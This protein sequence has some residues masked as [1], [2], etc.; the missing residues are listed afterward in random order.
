MK[1]LMSCTSDLVIKHAKAAGVGICII[2]C[3][4]MVST[5]TMAELIFRPING[6]SLEKELSYEETLE[7]LKDGLLLAGEQKSASTY[8]ELALLI[9]SGFVAILIEGQSE[10]LTVGVQGYSSRSVEEPS[11]HLNVRAARDSFVE[12]IRTNVSLI[13]RR[14]KTPQLVFKMKKLGNMSKTDVCICYMKNR[15]DPQLVREVEKRLDKIGLDS[16]LESGYLQPFLDVRG[17]ALFSEVGATERPDSFT[18]KLYG[19]RV[20]VLV[21]GSPFGLFL[22]QLFSENFTAMDDYTGRP[23]YS[24]VIRTMRYFAYFLSIMLAGFYVALANFNPELIPQTLLLN[25]S[26]SVQDTPYPLLLECI[27]IHIFFEMMREAG[28]RIPSNIGHA[29]SIVGGLVI[30]EIVVSAGLVGAPLVLIVAL[31][32]ICSFVVP[33]LYESIAVM[34]FCYIIA[35][36]MWGLFGLTVLTV[37]FVLKICSMNA[38]GVPATAPISPLT[39]RALRDVITR[40]GW[41]K[42]SETDVKIQDLNG[43]GING[44]QD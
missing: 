20:G 30:G 44:Q 18:A 7:Q 21:D 25:L 8:G 2:F 35:G 1:T 42:A 34:R 29:V 15:A 28:L 17:D 16:L 36:G 33:D 5:S 22:P 10:A 31:S 23:A 4:G 24:A 41:R 43:V 6:L 14:M 12:V 11:T 3:E 37:L 40:T 39:F 27:I 19:G 13:R 38:F 32:A 9:M 26:A